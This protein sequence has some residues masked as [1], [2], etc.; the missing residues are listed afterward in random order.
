MPEFEETTPTVNPDHSYSPSTDAKPRT[1]R[2]SGGFKKEYS[3]PTP[4]NIGEIDPTEALK[5]EKLSGGSKPA[6]QEARATKAQTKSTPKPERKFDDKPERKPR[7]EQPQAATEDRAPSATPQP[8]AE[9]LAAIER[10]ESRI[11]ERKA[12]RDAKHAERKKAHAAKKEAREQTNR[13][14]GHKPKA[15]TAAKKPGLLGSILKLFGLG[16]KEPVKPA[17]RGNSANRQ[18]GQGG[19]PQGKNGNRNYQNRSGGQGGQNRRKGNGQNRR[20]GQ[21]G[22]RRQHS[23]RE[24]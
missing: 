13:A 19:R 17:G 22:Q 20:R 15:Q 8:T 11:A 24:A 9:T 6:A 16:P 14:P 3:S 21:G 5:S 7:S 12:E 10:V 18:R 4:G 1:R 23:D 2:R